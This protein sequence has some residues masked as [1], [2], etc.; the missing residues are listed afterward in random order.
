MKRIATN[1][2]LSVGVSTTGFALA[3]PQQSSQPHA[4]HHASAE[5]LQSDISPEAIAAMDV[6]ERF[7]DALGSGDLETVEAL[8]APDVLVLES[9]GAERSREEYLGH[10]AASDAEFLQGVHRQVLRKR[11]RAAGGLAWVGSESELHTQR[12][13]KPLTVLSTETMVLR[14]M[15]EGWRI[16]H[17]HWSSQ[18]KR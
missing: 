17:I 15:P 3:Q 1:L 5:S 13:G 16:V 6:L 14:Q 18:T 12:E 4:H 10:H 7:N 2:L 8:L 11:A 9:G